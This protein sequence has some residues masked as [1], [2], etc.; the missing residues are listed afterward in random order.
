V[1]V[2]L[3]GPVTWRTPPEAYGPWEQIV[4]LLAEGLVAE[5]VDVTLFATLDSVTAAEL[6]GVCEQPYG[7]HPQMDG[8]IWE[9]LHVAYCAERSG[10]FDLVHNH[11]DWLPLAMAGLFR[12]PLLTTVHGFSSD[13]IKPAYD[14]AARLG[15]QYVSISDSDRAPGLPYIAT[16][17]HGIDLARFPFEPDAQG[18]LIAFGRIHPDKGTADAIEIARQVGMPLVICGPVHDAEYHRALVEP[19][20]DGERVRYPGNVGPEERMRLL[21][22]ATALVHPIGFAEPFGLSVVEA[23]ACG[24]PVVAYNKGSMPEIVEPGVTGYLADDVTGAVEGVERAAK[25]DRRAIHETAVRR[26]GAARMV[27]DYLDVYKRL[28]ALPNGGH[29]IGR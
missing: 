4:S 23:M 18:Y 3:L 29:S 12:A 14:H 17:H 10:D 11:L 13:R 1:K 2:A 5:G 26:F 9:S 19:H 25:L 15:A 7:S 16:V 6:D 8:R 21:G 20:I 28:L 24:T 22:E 27:R